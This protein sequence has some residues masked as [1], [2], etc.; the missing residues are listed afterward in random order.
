MMQQFL[1]HPIAR[2]SVKF[3]AYTAATVVI[4]LAIAVG[5]FR[6]FLPRL[7]EYQEEIKAWASNAIGLQVEFSGMDARWGLS[8]PE[9][10][11][12][13]AELANTETGARIVAA[14]E[15]R[16]GIG[17]VRLLMDR[18]LL[19]D[20]I[21]VRETSIDIQQLADGR[22]RIQGS[23]LEDLMQLRT[24]AAAQSVNMEIIGDDLEVRFMQAGDQRPRSFDIPDLRVVIDESRVV[25]N[26]LIRLPD[27]LGRQLTVVATQIRDPAVIANR[28]DVSLE[29]DNLNL[30]GW[31][32]L[33]ESLPE[34]SSGSGDV[35]LSLKIESG[36]F[37][38]AT[39][40]LDLRQV[41]LTPSARSNTETTFDLSGHIEAELA[42]DGWL[43]A[44]NDWVPTFA[45]HA[46][47]K[48]SLRVE[49]STQAD[50][51]VALL[52]VRASYLNLDDLAIVS[53]MLPD[54][55]RDQLR[56]LAPSG[57][58]VD[59]AA[60]LSDLNTDIVKYDI[61]AD[62][63]RIGVNAAFGRPGIRGFS[64]SLRADSSGGHLKI[65]SAD[66]EV[67]APEYVAHVITLDRADGTVIWRNGKDRTT[68]LS[69]SIHIS[70][71]VLDS[72]SNVQL[73]LNDDGSA[74]EID[75]ASSWSIADLAA[76]KRY[77]PHNVVKPKLYDWFQQALVK[78]KIERGTTELSGPLDKFPFDGGEGRLLINASVRNTTFQ[79]HPQWPAAEEANLEVVLDNARL[80]TR[81]NRST[82]A[83]NRVVDANVEIAD[84]RDPVLKIQ[85]LSTGSLE[86]IR[87]FSLQSPI[88][89][90]L[91]G[92]LDRI[93]VDGDASFTLDL[94]V[95]LK[96]VREFEFLARVRSNNGTL[97]VT[98]FPAPISDLIGEVSIARDS[99]SS[100]SLGGHF[101]GGPVNIDLTHSPDPQFSVIARAEGTATA[102]AV[103]SDLGAPVQDLID[104]QTSYQAK[105]L[106]P[107]G[108]T[109]DPAPL[110]IEVETNLLGS[111]VA[112]PAPLGKD[113]NLAIPIT[114]DVR[115][116]PGG[117]S[118]TS[119]GTASERFS[120]DL[121][122]NRD[123]NR[124]DGRWDFDRGM[125]TFG[126]ENIET[127]DTRGLHLRG[128]TPTV[129]LQ[130]WLA[131]SRGAEKKVGVADRIRSI[132]I[133]I[134]DL[135]IL[136]QHLV[137][138]RVQV[139]RSA[140]D[141]LVQ[142]DGDDITGSA[143]VPY[144]FAGGRA[145]VLEMQ[146][147]RLPGDENSE[148]IVATIDPRSLPAITITADEF[149]FG[150]RH[151]G[152]VTATI[153]KTPNGLDAATIQSK[154]ASF[155]IVGTGRWVAD[156]Q[157]A[158]GSRSFVTAT[159]TSTDV[160][161]TMARLNYEPGIIGKN[162]GMLFDLNWSGSPRADFFDTLDGEVQVRL[163]NGQ[164]REVEP[165][166]GRMLGLVSIVALPK[167]L[168]LDF[169]DVF[170]KGFGFD[171]IA[172]TFRI[173][174]GKT[175]TC[176]LALEG[177][178]ADIGI[179]GVAD[180]ANR[181]YNQTAIV[182]ANV[183]NSLPI[184]GAVVA[185][186]Q[187]GAALLIFSQIFKKPLKEVGQAYYA[188]GGSWDSTVVDSTDS[189]A[190]VASGELA[191]CLPDTR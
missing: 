23:A 46:W 185:G 42:E 143:F 55:Y 121:N 182:S 166:A 105:V 131:L 139:D 112:M 45:D 151:V 142:F 59:L 176:D 7:P 90:V 132:D 161:Q 66:V 57:E 125:V 120:W 28:W 84:L 19:V 180:I 35:D 88:A 181:T 160:E 40:N 92:Q 91:G 123:E 17:L 39:A 186:P 58:V 77:I 8:G 85:S 114:A 170:S 100:E 157:D 133:E 173:V 4:L 136:G 127:A 138:H 96:Q 70:S 37:R 99:I 135:Y 11:F 1:T 149:A 189:A 15:V 137:G 3:L 130:D 126:G 48:S 156:D 119:S 163:E 30:R 191:G 20:R 74:P 64:G 9:L 150:D 62:L 71:D 14:N 51:S 106:F 75:L 110:T 41:S 60:T 144:D 122:F 93:T 146:K 78:G 80:Y 148:A 47:P 6:L 164:L 83:G 68:V 76:A 175:Y 10:E 101:L 24:D 118:I 49:A 31:S 38:S 73:I 165:G 117:R 89:K 169:R 115:F 154:D 102:A 162:M 155:E 33:T 94:T 111:V 36:H 97:S 72:Q 18:D 128:R 69:D 56:D 113:V 168:S 179:V 32:Q 81:K 25:G 63:R 82:S 86:S 141:W 29:G 116:L 65:Q 13:D 44:A 5:L 124:P 50:R 178:A 108:G 98:G 177:P 159:L 79:Y 22:F 147:L 187:V 87:Q 134:D 153:E 27:D 109:D 2:R 152:A 107:R 95:P 158:L 53:P 104:G 184:V 103:S 52:D 174:D 26:A 171:K 183:G 140:L 54:Q 34:F 167:R 16:V 129:R 67:N 43:V 190:F 145:M 188:I 61:S 12:Y 172:G 21:V